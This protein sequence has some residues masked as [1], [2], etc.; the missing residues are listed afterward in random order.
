MNLNQFINLKVREGYFY[1]YKTRDD[2]IYILRCV[3]ELESDAIFEVL[4]IEHKSE[5]TLFK[6][7]DRIRLPK[8]LFE[9]LEFIPEEEGFIYLI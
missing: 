9:F 5:T 3:L 6:K 4:D 8:E 2:K 1:R 7:G